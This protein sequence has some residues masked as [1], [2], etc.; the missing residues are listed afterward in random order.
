MGRFVPRLRRLFVVTDRRLAG[1]ARA[2][3]APRWISSRSTLYPGKEVIE[4]DAHSR[5]PPLLTVTNSAYGRQK[6]RAIRSGERANNRL[7]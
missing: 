4:V 3:A 5:R 1:A 7:Y 6:T 2:P